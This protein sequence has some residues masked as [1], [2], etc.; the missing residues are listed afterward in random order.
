MAGMVDDYYGFREKPF[1]LTPDPRFFYLS[2]DHLEALEHL[3]FGIHEGEGFLLLVGAIGTGKTTLSRVL[4]DRLGGQAITSLVLNPFQEYVDLLRNILWDFG[5][6]PEGATVNE[7]TNQLI[8]FLLNEAGPKGKSALVIIDEAQNLNREALEQLRI[9]SNVETDKEKLLQILLLGQEEL[10]AKLQAAE[11][12]QLYQRISVKYFLSPL[13]RREVGRYIAHRLAVCRPARP[14]VFTPAALRA[15]YRFS[16]GI[17]RLINMI[18]SRCLVAGFVRETDR[19]DS[20]M[21]RRARSS[22]FGE[23]YRRIVGFR[24]EADGENRLPFPSGDGGPPL[25]G[26]GGE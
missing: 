6:I 12:R 5:V 13:P 8:D 14:V 1:A 16:R 15:V 4:I 11:L 26:A 22:L 21:V 10:L 3:A 25:P 19:I 20:G 17:P 9:L 18:A 7:L 24:R 2:A 23:K